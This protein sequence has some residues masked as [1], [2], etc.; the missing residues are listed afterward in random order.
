MIHFFLFLSIFSIL[1]YFLPDGF[2]SV[3]MKRD[4]YM[5]FGKDGRAAPATLNHD[6]VFSSP[7]LPVMDS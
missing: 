1:F 7:W 6:G 5:D 3:L 2:A 4:I